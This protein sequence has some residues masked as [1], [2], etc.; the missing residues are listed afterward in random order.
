MCSREATMTSY[1]IAAVAAVSSANAALSVLACAAPLVTGAT[2]DD[3]R[4][5]RKAASRS[6]EA[7]RESGG[8]DRA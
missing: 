8:L 2:K 3:R 6:E 4:A 7:V 5:D 1:R